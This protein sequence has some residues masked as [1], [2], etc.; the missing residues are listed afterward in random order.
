M[1]SSNRNRFFGTKAETL[2]FLKSKLIRSTICDAVVFSV[3]DWHSNKNHWIE[4][5]QK[6]FTN[7]DVIVRSSAVDEDSPMSAMAGYYHS[8]G[9]VFSRDKP[10]L[11]TAIEQDELGAIMFLNRKRMQ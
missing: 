4:M 8:V 3:T 6:L 10:A 2:L 11:K 9:N 7:G 5:I 1:L